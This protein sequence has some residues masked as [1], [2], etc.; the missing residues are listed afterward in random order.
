MIPRR[1]PRQIAS[2]AVI[3]LAVITAR[4][5]AQEPFAFDVRYAKEV[6]PGPLSARVYV[7]L[8][9][10]TGRG[11]EPRTRPLEFN[12]DPIFAIQAKDWKA[13]EPLHVGRE[14]LGYPRPLNG[15]RRGRYVAQA[16][17]RLNPDTHAIGVGEGNAYG[18]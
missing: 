6:A 1:I 14:A 12:P 9:R 4:A 8:A 17:V 18:P 3:A 11:G 2:A 13:G 10:D 15:L 7:I 5:N 16:V